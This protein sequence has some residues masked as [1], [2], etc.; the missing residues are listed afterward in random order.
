MKD[1]NAKISLEIS[2]ELKAKLEKLADEK[3]MSVSGL[4]RLIL[5]NYLK[6]D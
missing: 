2:K 6:E 3:E 5:K 1:T 4:I